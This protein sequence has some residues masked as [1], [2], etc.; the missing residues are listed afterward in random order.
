ME[1]RGLYRRYQAWASRPDD[2]LERASRQADYNNFIQMN[3]F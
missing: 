2:A 3:P 1:L